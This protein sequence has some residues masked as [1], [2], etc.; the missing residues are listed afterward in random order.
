MKLLS[1]FLVALAFASCTND[2]ENAALPILS[3]QKL[4]SVLVNNEWR[5]D[6]VF[7]KIPDF[8]FTSQLNKTITQTDFEGKIYVADFFF[9]SCPTICPKMTKN[10]LIVQEKFKDEDRFRILSHSIDTRNDDPKRLFEYGS[11]YGINSKKWLLVTGNRDSIYQI[12]EKSYFSF[13]AED[14]T[15]PGGYVHQGYFLLIDE[16]KLI[17][18]VYDGTVEEEVK[19]LMKDIAILLKENG[20]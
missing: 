10:M 7:E 18:G 12:G 1:L 20:K 6:T 5:V 16:N 17:R 4:D 9:T 14:N 8:T 13:I 15:E 19:K 2:S 3:K 11:R